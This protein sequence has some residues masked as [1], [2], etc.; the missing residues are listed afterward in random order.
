MEAW[1]NS[2]GNSVGLWL[3]RTVNLDHVKTICGGTNGNK[4][5]ETRNC[6]LLDNCTGVKSGEIE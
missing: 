2:I 4:A 6:S 3:V 1:E 5:D